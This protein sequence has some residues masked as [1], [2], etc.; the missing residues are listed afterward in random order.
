[1]RLLS[2][3]VVHGRGWMAYLL[4]VDVGMSMV[5]CFVFTSECEEVS[6]SQ[7]EYMDVFEGVRRIYRRRC[8]LHTGH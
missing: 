1:M 3:K 4:G 2:V 8:S 6:S 7:G 5:K